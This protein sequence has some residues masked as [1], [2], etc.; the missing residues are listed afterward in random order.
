MRKI[1]RG[2]IPGVW[3][4]PK[5]NDCYR[6]ML[7]QK[8]LIIDD[9]ADSRFLLAKTLLRKFPA[10]VLVECA[11]EDTA[12]TITATERLSAVVVHR[13][14]SVPG[15]ELLPL[16]RR[17]NA[18]VPIVLVSGIDRAD[19]ARAAGATKFLLYDEWLMLGSVVEALMHAPA[20]VTAGGASQPPWP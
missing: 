3:H 10:A 6:M 8:F 17:A 12:T 2:F 7:P 1:R 14:A 4:D 15:L 19:A 11:D 16:L 9:N 20:A 18:A 13:S 5:R